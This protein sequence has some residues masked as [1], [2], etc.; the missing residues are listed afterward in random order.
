MYENTLHYIRGREIIV[1]HREQQTTSAFLSHPL[2]VQKV[3]DQ[4]RSD[5][6]SPVL[7][8][9]PKPLDLAL[10]FGKLMY[11]GGFGDAQMHI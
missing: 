5:T 2:Q 3:S 4:I 7:S 8:M 11:I 10:T 9:W 6:T 1:P